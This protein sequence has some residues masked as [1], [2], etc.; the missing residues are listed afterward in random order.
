V[1]LKKLTRKHFIASL[2]VLLLGS[3][4][5]KKFKSKRLDK[6]NHANNQNFKAFPI[7]GDLRAKPKKSIKT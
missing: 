5:W 6:N 4:S 2:A 1:T 7:K 3:W